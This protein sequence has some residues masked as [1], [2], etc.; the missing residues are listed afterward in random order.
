MC[1]ARQVNRKRAGESK[2]FGFRYMHMDRGR[3]SSSV[4]QD[5]HSAADDPQAV[6]LEQSDGLG[7]GDFFFFEYAVGEGVGRVIFEHGADALEDNRAVV[8]LLIDEVNGAAGD[9]AAVGEDGFVNFSAVHSGAAE[10]GEER[11]VNVHD[12]AVVARGNGEHAQPA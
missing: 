4:G 11:G 12:A 1:S 5:L 2:S 3:T 8:V 6:L 7:V 10:A 9:F